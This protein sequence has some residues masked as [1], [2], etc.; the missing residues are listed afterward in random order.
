MA[1]K[2]VVEVTTSTATLSKNQSGA[3]VVLNRAAGITVTLPNAGRGIEYDFAVET[4]ATNNGIYKLIG[5][6]SASVRGV[7]YVASTGGGGLEVGDGVTHVAVSL[8]SATGGALGTTLKA[9]CDDDGV[10]TISGIAA[11]TETETAATPYA[12][13]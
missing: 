7:I 13:S 10:W 9:I 11:V 12:T 1:R 2:R 3:L 4:A 8:D 6:D 5:N